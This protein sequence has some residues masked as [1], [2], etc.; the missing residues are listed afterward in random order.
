MPEQQLQVQYVPISQLKMWDKNPRKNDPTVASI[1]KSIER[2]GYTNPILARRDN[3]EVIAGHTR[4]KALAQLGIPTAPVIFLDLSEDEA[5]AYA[6]F[7]NKSTENTPWDKPLLTDV[8]VELKEAGM[9]LELTGFSLPEIGKLLPDTILLDEVIP[10]E[11]TEYKGIY[12]Y[13]EDV[14][15]PS[16]NPWGLPD[17]REDMLGTVPPTVTWGGQGDHEDTPYLYVYRS[18]AMPTVKKAGALA[19]YIDDEKFDII[20]Y[21]AVYFVE[22]MKEQKFDNLIGPDFSLWR[23]TPLAMQLYN[24]FRSRWCARYWQEAG[25]KVIPSLNWSDE[26]TYEWT[27]AG[28]PKRAPVVAV[29]CRTT[30][31]RLGKQFFL[32]GLTHGIRELEP[33]NV[34][35]YGGEPH[36]QW[37]A[38]NLPDGPQY[39]YLS[40]H[41]VARDAFRASTSERKTKAKVVSAVR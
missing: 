7:D 9:D 41:K 3:N 17:L 24:T 34:V 31:S 2:F 22:Q 12:A 35:I 29:Q 10:P 25:F 6:V 19:F 28:F 15:F 30:R 27:F 5:H 39:H 1:V 20:W 16:N 37:L 13:E 23:D 36:Y 4:L 21:N 33:E 8:M 32:K 18:A 40:D 11:K 14:V 38:A 26:S